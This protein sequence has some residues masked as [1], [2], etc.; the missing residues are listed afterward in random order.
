MTFSVVRKKNT[1]LSKTDWPAY[2]HQY[3]ERDSGRIRTERLLADRWVRWLYGSARE[4]APKVFKALVSPRASAWLACLNYDLPWGERL[5]GARRLASM[6][7]IDL[8]ECVAPLNQLSTP[9]RIFERQ[10]KY[11]HC[12]PMPADEA[13][14]VAPADAKILMGALS[15]AGDLFLKEKFFSYAELLGQSHQRWLSAFAQGDFAVLR[16]TPEKYHYNHLPVSGRVADYYT[17][18]G[19]CHS[20]NPTAV[21]EMITPFSKNRRHVTI[22]DTDVP[23]GTQVGLVAM[24]EIVALMI[25]GIEQCYSS[26]AYETPQPMRI[27]LP[28]IKGQPKSLFRPGSS[29]DVLLFQPGRMR[30]DKDLLDN[31]AR[32]NVRSRFCRRFREPLVETEV[33]VRSSIGRRLH[34]AE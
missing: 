10:I 3:V 20:C 26:V 2:A 17:I 24:I 34:P 1:M 21:V 8:T 27:G 28:V 4:T 13:V 31:L 6:L 5:T 18:D 7:G 32:V 30:F 16:L 11:W 29:V 25:G 14:I 22:I 23:G 15:T 9:R 12:R 19:L 33:R